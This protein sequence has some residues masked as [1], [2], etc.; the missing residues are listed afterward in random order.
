[1]TRQDV[2]FLWRPEENTAFE[3]LKASITS[4]DTMAFFDPRKQIVVQTEA[5][6]H[7]GLSAGLFQRTG[8][9]LQ[10]VH[11]ISRSMTSAEKRYSQT[12]KDALAV[13]W[14]KTRF[15]IYLLGAPKFKIITSNKPLIPMFSKA[16]SKNHQELRNGLW[17]CRTLIMKLFMNLEKDAADPMDY[18]SRHPLPETERDNTE[19]NNKC[20]NQQ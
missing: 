1:M 5:S 16:C 8:K 12:E 17:K 15:G 19:K 9:G 13:K 7:E 10:P 3:K 11:Y 14:A 18:L 6:F 4:D 2:P 20:H